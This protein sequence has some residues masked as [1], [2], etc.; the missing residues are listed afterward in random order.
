MRTYLDIGS[1]RL[2][3]LSAAVLIYSDGAG[4]FAT[5]H[6]VKLPPEEG[7]PYIGEA[8]PLT[9]AFLR[10]LAQGLG[11]RVAPEILP[12]SVL[13]RTLEM[14]AW[15]SPAQHRTM[16]FGSHSDAHPTLN[17]KRFPQPALVFKVDAGRLFVRALAEN[18]RP[19]AEA[20]LRTAP[21]WNT[22]HRGFVC[23]GSMR[24]PEETNAESIL[25]WERAYFQS[26]FTH[27][28][29]AT[30][31]TSFPGGFVAL[32][33]SLVGSEDD[34]PVEF[35]TDARQTLQQFIEESQSS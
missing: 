34:F 30:R 14:I 9:T 4:A 22:D 11:S 17:G 27:A 33:K 8:Q 16:F 35:L 29:G 13:A 28:Y 23:T 15:W 5:Q 10:H 31:L 32:W 2:L 19:Q 12:V 3:K 24:V 1:R 25:A 26:E 6:E 7:A 21:Y 18:R 20:K